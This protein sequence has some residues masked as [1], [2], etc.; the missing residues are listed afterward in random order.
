ML[1]PLCTVF[2]AVN[3]FSEKWLFSKYGEQLFYL[4][5]L[6]RVKCKEIFIY[7]IFLFYVKLFFVILPKELSHGITMEKIIEPINEN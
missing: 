4:N 5:P 7:S 2:S 3:K 6:T 1:C